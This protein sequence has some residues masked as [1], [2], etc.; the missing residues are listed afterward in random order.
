MKVGLS[1]IF[2]PCCSIGMTEEEEEDGRG[3][4]PSFS[5]LAS[6]S[7]NG[8]RFHYGETGFIRRREVWCVCVGKCSLPSLFKA[9]LAE[10]GE[11]LKKKKGIIKIKM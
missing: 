3:T 9:M 4:L 8:E 7:G 10:K 6:A 11:A 1:S 2:F 5:L